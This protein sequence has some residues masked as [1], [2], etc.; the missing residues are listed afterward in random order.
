M[1]IALRL[2]Y[3]GGS[4]FSEAARQ[5]LKT[6][7]ARFPN[8]EFEI[9]EIDVVLNPSKAEEDGVLATPTIIKF[10]PSP[11]AKIVCDFTDLEKALGL[12]RSPSRR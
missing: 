2:F 1:K 3:T 9:E 6:L 7:Q 4:P 5:E 10:S 8:V 12:K 11:V